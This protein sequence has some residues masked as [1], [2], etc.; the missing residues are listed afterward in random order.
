MRT[1][2][3]ARHILG[4]GSERG[5]GLVWHYIVK[6]KSPTTGDVL[7]VPYIF[8]TPWQSQLD[9]FV[10]AGASTVAVPG[11]RVCAVFDSEVIRDANT[12][13][14]ADRRTPPRDKTW[15]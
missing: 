4:P 1:V 13:K 15:P 2:V 8:L 12:P 3:Q 14:V 7:S 9:G 6:S 11:I 5:A 10:Y